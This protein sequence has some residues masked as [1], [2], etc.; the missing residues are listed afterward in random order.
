MRKIMVFQHVGHEP[1]G[2]LDPML[3]AAGFRIRYVNFGRDPDIVPSL[4]SYNGLIVL[5][6]PMGVYESAR[7]PHLKTEMKLIEEALRREI[8]VLGIC[9]GAQLLAAALGAEVCKAPG[10]EFGWCDVEVTE[11][12]KGDTLFQTYNPTETVFQ[13]HQDA[14]TVPKSAR[15][16][17]ASSACP[18]QAFSYNDKAY[19]L[20][21][22]LEADQAMI[23]RWLGRPENKRLIEELHE[24]PEAL[25]KATATHIERSLMLSRDT[26]SKFIDIF[27][28]PERPMILGSEHGRPPKGK[29]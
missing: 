10:W 20:Q 1:L 15:H 13:I 25:V 11:A 6:G 5:G 23:L 28:L 9:L 17:A 8:P 14:F 21:F 18:G 29:R 2:T 3:K 4:D 12:G 19:G 16:L 7:Y 22:H 24:S 27:Q 26:F